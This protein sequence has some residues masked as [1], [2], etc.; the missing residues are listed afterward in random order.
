M[1]F[2]FSIEKLVDI[3]GS[4]EVEGSTNQE[5]TDIA[6]LSNAKAGDLSF[7]GNKKYTREVPESAASVILLPNTYEGS[8]SENQVFLRL[9][10]P[11]LALA[12]LCEEIEKLLM[13]KPATGIHA[14]ATVSDSATVDPT[15]TIGPGCV[16]SDGAKIG[17][18]THL[19][20][21]VFIGHNVTIGNDCWIKP[22]VTVGDYCEIGNRVR[23]HAGAV[24]G[25]DGFG[26]ETVNGVHHKVPQIGNVVVEDDV[27]I[28]ANSTIDRA[29]FSSTRIGAGTKI[30]NLVQIAHNVE[31]GKGCIIVAQT[32]IS[33]STVLE[34]YVVTAG[35][36]GIAGHLKLAKGT[37][38]AAKSG[39][40]SS[41]SPGQVLF[42]IPAIDANLAHRTD[43]L[44]KRLPD[45][46]KRVAKLEDDLKTAE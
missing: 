38:I 12:K 5:I 42:G 24:I 39:L 4:A 11:S 26:Y 35:Q 43:V 1:R 45:L 6:S 3:I 22:H 18:G 41:T 33:G 8:P 37:V 10:N 28:G 32:G 29:R 9:E 2:S 23:L 40:H 30:D 21:T 31:T 14:S 44:K 27:E 7:L 46:F 36:A 16:I 17:A 20:A 25:S 19:E 34:D 15:A 13:P